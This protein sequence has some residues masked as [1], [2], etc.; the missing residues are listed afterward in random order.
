MI[1]G[2]WENP[3]PER[4]NLSQGDGI[5]GGMGYQFLPPLSDDERKAL[6]ESIETFGVLHHVVTDEDGAIIDG[7]HRAEVA[8]ELGI[9]YPTTVLPGLSEEEKI[10]TALT[11]NLGRR[12]LDLEDKQALVADLRERG[13]S[14]RW[15]S[16][17]T[18]I[19]KSTVHRYS[20]RVPGGTPEYVGGRDGKTYQAEQGRKRFDPVKHLEALVEA[21]PAFFDPR[22]DHP[23]DPEYQ[24]MAGR[25]WRTMGTMAASIPGVSLS[26]H[27]LG[28]DITWRMAY[29]LV[30]ITER[31]R[32]HHKW[33]REFGESHGLPLDLLKNLVTVADR[34]RHDPMANLETKEDRIALGELERWRLG[35]DNESGPWA[36]GADDLA[37]IDACYW[38]VSATGE[39]IEELIAEAEE[40][41]AA[42]HPSVLHGPSLE[43]Y[44]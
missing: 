17:K 32:H 36:V 29:T 10:E 12:H 33:L 30:A 22:D 13:L 21:I 42:G 31:E 25:S 28:C 7:H 4:G 18:G 37:L 20:Q 9:E 35:V 6:R 11:L 16:E 8:A 23:A 24:S 3:R 34:F 5:R 40:W 19:P 14:V 15:I 27:C 41:L 1:I 39:Q 26:G 44:Q 38:G 43:S 2:E